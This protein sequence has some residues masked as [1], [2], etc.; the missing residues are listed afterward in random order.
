MCSPV[1]ESPSKSG[2]YFKYFIYLRF[3]IQHSNTELCSH[4]S[5]SERD[6][7][8]CNEKLLSTYEHHNINIHP[9]FFFLLPHAKLTDVDP[10]SSDE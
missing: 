4:L 3:L 10:L 2:S 9:F 8:M 6:K 1:C 5:I 7:E